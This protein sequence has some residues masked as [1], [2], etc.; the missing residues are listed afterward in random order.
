MMIMMMV[1]M[2]MI[3]MM[4]V[5][6]DRVGGWFQVTT[7]STSTVAIRVAPCSDPGATRTHLASPSATAPS[8][9]VVSHLSAIH[10]HLNSKWW[11]CSSVA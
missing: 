6:D 5:V 1:M 3:M 8:P 9:L 2:L 11:G 4:I 7:C 10:T